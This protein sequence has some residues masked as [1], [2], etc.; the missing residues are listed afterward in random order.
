MQWTRGPE[1][2]VQEAQKRLDARLQECHAALAAAQPQTHAALVAARVEKEHA[3]LGTTHAELV[4]DHAALMTAHRTLETKHAAV[5]AEVAA[6][7]ARQGQTLALL[8][9]GHQRQLLQMQQQLHALQNRLALQERSASAVIMQIVQ[10]APAQGEGP[11]AA[12]DAE[13]AAS[14]SPPR[15]RQAPR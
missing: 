2:E 13:R 14:G 9:Q 10:S 7:G 15:S 5:V 8:Q 1:Q 3:A 6:Q 4:A 12:V 11:P